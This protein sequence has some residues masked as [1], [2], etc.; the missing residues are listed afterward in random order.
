MSSPLV[1]QTILPVLQINPPSA[2]AFTDNGSCAGHSLH[3]SCPR[4]IQKFILYY[5]KRRSSISFL[6][7]IKNISVT[8]AKGLL[9]ARSCIHIIL[10]SSLP[11]LFSKVFSEG[12]SRL[13][14]DNPFHSF[15]VFTVRKFLP[16]SDLNLPSFSVGLLPSVIQLQT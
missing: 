13:S 1:M 3:V 14:T 8:T 6:K 12:D 5:H 2:I 11:S 16:T 9:T 4:L 15:N 7:S 10:E